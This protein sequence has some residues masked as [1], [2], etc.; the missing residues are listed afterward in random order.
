MER[1]TLERE[2]AEEGGALHGECTD[3]PSCSSSFSLPFPPP[4]PSILCPI[5]SF[6]FPS[7]TTRCCCCC[8]FFF[9][10][11]LFFSR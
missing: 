2:E 3:M 1:E 10:F 5:F 9:V 6:Q 8:D 11:L 4:P 7:Q